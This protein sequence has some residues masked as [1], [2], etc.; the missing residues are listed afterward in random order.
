MAEQI[1]AQTLEQEIANVPVPTPN[2]V[3]DIDDALSEITDDIP[4]NNNRKNYSDIIKAE[5]AK[6][7]VTRYDKIKVKNVKCERMDEYVRITFVIDKAIPAYVLQDDGTYKIGTSTNIFSSSYAISGML[8]E[9]EEQA[10]LANEILEACDRANEEDSDKPLG[11]INLLFNGS[12]ISIISTH[13]EANTPY[14]NPF[15]TQEDPEPYMSDNNF[16]ANNVIK[17]TIGK[18]GK[19]AVNRLMDRLLGF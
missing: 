4:S 16:F 1:N 14:I 8:K 19:V 18:T 2:P 6:P 12:T 5:V 13:V 17:I 11:I 9:Y 7:N 10:W 15:T 3:D